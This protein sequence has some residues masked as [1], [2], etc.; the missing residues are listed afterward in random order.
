MMTTACLRCTVNNHTYICVHNSLQSFL[1]KLDYIKLDIKLKNIM[2][3]I[4]Q[5][6]NLRVHNFKQVIQIIYHNYFDKFN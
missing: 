2:Q 1:C 3:I 4:A 6:I 5:L